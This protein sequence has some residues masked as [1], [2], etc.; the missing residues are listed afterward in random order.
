VRR[1]VV[2][3]A[4]KSPYPSIGVARF[5]F[6]SEEEAADHDVLDRVICGAE[7]G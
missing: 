4:V 3:A 1:Y 5:V 7:A 6:L 2:I